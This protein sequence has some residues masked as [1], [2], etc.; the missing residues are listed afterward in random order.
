M[1]EELDLRYIQNRVSHA[2][3]S[4]SQEG[5]SFNSNGSKK[6][7][8]KVGKEEKKRRLLSGT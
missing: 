2:L 6:R 1:Q 7:I 8:K 5:I 3:L 4:A